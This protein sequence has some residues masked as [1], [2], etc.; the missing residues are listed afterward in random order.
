MY[1]KAVIPNLALVPFPYANVESSF[2][3]LPIA[4]NCREIQRLGL[5]TSRR[6]SLLEMRF[7]KCRNI[8]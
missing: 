5:E 2:H 8:R 7:N 4:L 1:T 6:F 3:W